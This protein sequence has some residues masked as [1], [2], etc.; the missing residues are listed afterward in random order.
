MKKLI[1]VFL[2]ILFIGFSMNSFAQ[3]SGY[4]FSQSAG[5]YTEITGTLFD[6]STSTS[7]LTSLDD[8]VYLSRAI[9]FDF[10][11]NGVTYTTYNMN[12]NGQVTFGTTSPGAGNYTPISS[13][14]LYA[15]AIA[16]MGKDLQ[17]LFGFT[18]TRTAASSTLTGVTDFAGIVVGK[19]IS[20]T[21]IA[22]GTRCTGFNIGLGEVYLSAAAT[23]AGTTTLNCCSAE[24][25]SET[26]GSVGSRVH[27]IQWKNFKRYSS[28]TLVDNFNFQIKL[29]EGTNI[30]EI[31]YGNY[32]ANTTAIQI[33]VGL[34]GPNN[35]D[36][37][38][39]K[40]AG[41]AWNAT[42]A[43]TLNTDTCRLVSTNVP[44][45]GLTFQYTPPVILNDVAVVANIAPSGSYI[46]GSSPITPIAKIK[47][48]GLNNQLTPFMIVYKITG[49][50]TYADS[51]ADTISAG[52]DHNVSFPSQF[53]PTVMGI[54]NVT[55]Y[56]E[57]S[58]DQNRF[59]DTL[60]T[61]FSVDP[62]PNYGN[63]SGY[64]F[65]NNLA[66]TQPS[67]PRW[68][69]KDTTGSKNLVLNGVSQQTVTGSLD[70]GYWKKSIKAIMLECNQDTSLFKKIKFNG[71]LYDSIF[72]GTNGIIGLTEAFGTYSI[73][74]FNIDGAQVAK[75]AILPLWHD[76][77][78][79]NTTGGS[80]RLSYKIKQNQ[81]IIT[82]DRAVSFAP[83]TD[84]VT[85][86]VVIGLV[87][88]AGED[89]SNW[90]VTFADTT[91][92]RTS[93]SFLAN[94]L[95]QYP[96][97]P[98]AATTFRNFVM[99]WSGNGAPNAYAGYVSS[100]NPFPASPVTQ[101]SVRRPIFNTSTG[102]G[103]AIEFGPDINSLNTHEGIL[104][105]LG[106]SF[107][108][109]QSNTRVRD[110][111]DIYLRD[112][113]QAPYKIMEYYRVYLDSIY[114]GSYNLGIAQIEF[115]MF[116]RGYPIYFVIKH[117]NSIRSWSP[118]I[119]TL[120]S[121]LA[122][123]FTAAITSIYGSNGVLVN[124]AASFFA[125]DITQDG[126]VD[127][128]DGALV[129]NDA[130][131]FEAGDYLTTDLNWDG[132]VDGADGVF[133]DN[134]ASNFVG[135][136]APPGATGIVEPTVVNYNYNLIYEINKSLPDVYAQP[137]IDLNSVTTEKK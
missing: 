135:E 107:E 23:S 30:I 110:T 134:N 6:S 43:G 19:I 5:A 94:Y 137:K 117:R 70:D 93:S 11:F 34:R 59:N 83:T 102:A 136:I 45:S 118:L 31:V 20:G 51:T 86:Q 37:N 57:L 35:T 56:T 25:R 109:L 55:I 80:N 78:L 132:I 27:T 112:G 106:M 103:L 63:D 67:Y 61:S 96:S 21:G 12:T 73:S 92:Q 16:G 68:S 53:N 76:N 114:N 3:I 2:L 4:T 50:V 42:V 128:A 77:N 29:Y 26:T 8:V 14:V 101:M 46:V 122:H 131:N 38:N 28:A 71:A 33:Q 17:G 89:N 133:T 116:K 88:G 49:P 95:A 18:A 65:A 121:N 104:V 22:A 15:G 41:G 125:G 87:K 130:S 91:N 120:S 10:A 48:N 127:G 72:I 44:A 39:R 36:F 79:S 108:G 32:Q 81:L 113:N 60:K 7:G 24:L 66:T 52:L 40:T 123:D 75:N 99:G 85:Y 54:Y 90:R 74:D 1:P 58:T 129:D 69:W 119:S 97:T 100:G 9:G 84:W 98:P 115:S 111:V 82:Y 47:N 64:Y 62:Q 126:V 124:G 105:T 13:T